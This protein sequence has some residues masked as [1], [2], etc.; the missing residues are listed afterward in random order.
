MF[1]CARHVVHFVVHV[2]LE[3]I[4]FEFFVQGFALAVNHDSKL[5]QAE[6]GI[7]GPQH[8]KSNIPGFLLK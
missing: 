1:D 5:V 7:R 2:A 3:T 4:K 8:L 6:R